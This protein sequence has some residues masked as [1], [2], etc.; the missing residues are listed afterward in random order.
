M[1]D[2]ST[3]L[4]EQLAFGAAAAQRRD[5]NDANEPLLPETEFTGF[6]TTAA[7]RNITDKPFALAL[8]AATI[9]WLVSGFTSVG[10]ADMTWLSQLN[11]SSQ[12]LAPGQFSVAKIMS[13]FLGLVVFSGA[14]A[15]G[16]GFAWIRIVQLYPLKV[17]SFSF[18]TN[19][20]LWVGVFIT[21]VSIGSLYLALAGV[22]LCAVYVFMY[23]VS[24]SAIERTATLLQ[25]AS[26]VTNSQP[27][28]VRLMFIGALGVAIVSALS[29]WFCVAAYSSGSVIDCSGDAD[30]DY[31]DGWFGTHGSSKAFKPATWSFFVLIFNVLVFYTLTHFLLLAQLFV[32]TYVTSIWFFHSTDESRCCSAIDNGVAAAQ[33]QSGTIAVAAFVQAVV[34]TLVYFCERA[35]MLSR[36]GQN[37]EQSCLQRAS[38]CLVRAFLRFDFLFALSVF[39]V[40]PFFQILAILCRHRF[41]ILRYVCCHHWTG[42]YALISLHT[43][44]SWTERLED[45]HC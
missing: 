17:V 8:A 10:R 45:A 40:I 4:P 38:E 43:A 16:C 11:D 5:L 35:L 20:A 32:T 44:C 21:G 37:S 15:C 27:S 29:S 26:R 42:L 22:L 9:V 30:C 13:V 2:H 1:S 34:D 6:I 23:M 31:Q 41:T 12:S 25:Y 36:Q 7:E 19:I 28:L 39:S 3:F 33:L 14:A 18:F 24:A